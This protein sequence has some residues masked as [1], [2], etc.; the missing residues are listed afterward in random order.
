MKRKN[1]LP[2]AQSAIRRNSPL[3]RPAFYPFNPFL[4]V[5]FFIFIGILGYFP[6]ATEETAVII[7][8]VYFLGA[9]ILNPL[10]GIY[11]IML[12][13]P[14]FLGNS[15]RPFFL[16]IEFF[17]YTS[18]LSSAAHYFIRKPEIRPSKF[19]IPVIIFAGAAVLS[20]PLNAKEII[21]D[22]R[23][24]P[25]AEI[26]RGLGSSH[27]GS[28]IYYFRSLFNS[29]SSI[30]LF[31]TAAIFMKDEKCVTRIFKPALAVLVINA[32]AAGVLFF[33]PQPDTGSYLS[34]SLAGRHTI[35][36][37]GPGIS[38][39]A[40]HR[41][42]FS[43]Y[44]SVFYPL[45][46]YYILNIGRDRLS[47]AASTLIFLLV[48]SMLP[49][50]YQRASV[51]V[52]SGQALILSAL[53][54]RAFGGAGKKAGFFMLGFAGA[55]VIF[56]LADYFLLGGSGMERLRTAG[57]GR[58][59]LWTVAL[60]M[61]AGNPLLGV[62]HGRFLL[63]FREY[64]GYAGIDFYTVH[65][66]RT[67]AHNVYLHILAEQGL[68]GLGSFLLL[69]GA[70]F[71]FIFKHIKALSPD[72]RKIIIVLSV[73][74]GGWLFYGITQHTFYI[75]SMQVFFWINLSF[76][77]AVLKEAAGEYKISRGAK[78]ALCLIF[79]AV[80][81]ARI[82]QAAIHPYPENYYGGFH[83]M[84]MQSEGRTARWIGERAVIR[85]PRQAGDLSIG[86]K[87]PT[88]SVARVP[89]EVRISLNGTDKR[90]ILDDTNYRS[91]VF[92]GE[93]I[94]GPFLW[95]KFENAY[96]VT[97][98]REG[99]SDDGRRLGVMVYEPRWEQD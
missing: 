93:T 95:I 63:S 9:V 65:L 8:C 53:I 13:I 54:L 10:N 55:A 82:Y 77:Y 79:A 73:S 56:Y 49:L 59:E 66:Y 57:T 86:L 97:P 58:T 42:Y 35:G 68:I 92:P 44:L 2:G 52:L 3:K 76:I 60:A 23:L 50:T 29:L 5:A 64:C 91:V 12:A 4:H 87:C 24:W 83:R 34:L 89:Q 96:T 33:R 72:R 43:Q 19:F 81:C 22:L 14:F 40:F 30:L 36:D 61:F 6:G 32:A 37:Y 90:I 27:E 71:Y 67:T 88:P 18:L 84:E 45:A 74:M 70:V 31:F 39:F 47:G 16:L 20:I 85:I 51:I 62:G 11:F 15:K 75:R 21:W 48:L 80:L 38:G 26:I 7:V 28:S 46:G 69:A 99:W 1:H 25:A 98:R 17:I 78:T 41:G 94:T